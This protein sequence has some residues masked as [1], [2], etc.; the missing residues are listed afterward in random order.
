[1]MDIWIYGIIGAGSVIILACILFIVSQIIAMLHH[2][3]HKSIL[4]FS[5]T[6]LEESL[7]YKGSDKGRVH[8]FTY[9]EIEDFSEGF[10]NLVGRGSNSYVYKGILSDGTEVAVKRF[11]DMVG[12]ESSIEK[13]F[14]SGSESSIEKGFRSKVE[15]LSQVHHQNL[16]NLIGYC[17]EKN[18]R[19]LVLQ[20]APNGTLYENLHGGEQLSWRQRMRIAVGTAYGLSYLHHSC[21]P[22]LLFNG[23]FNSSNIFLTEDY[24]AKITGLGKASG[25]GSELEVKSYNDNNVHIQQVETAKA[26]DVYAF[27]ILLLELLSGREASSQSALELIDLAKQ[28]LHCNDKMPDIADPALKNVAAGEF[29]AICEIACRCV[30]QDTKI[31]PNMEDVIALLVQALGIGFET[32][33]PITNP[34]TLRGLGEIF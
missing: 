18:Y 31:R 19:M 3:L 11:K 26:G 6:K 16:I 33:A 10:S 25:R 28:Y 21:N 23:K 22:P 29:N 1:M 5:R 30:Q 17:Q 12:N 27:G 7:D 32:A 24:A 9:K 34:L 15:L 2:R 8:L 13:R 14:R 20:Y 4:P